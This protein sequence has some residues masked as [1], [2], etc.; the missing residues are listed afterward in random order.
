MS[1]IIQEI[2]KTAQQQDSATAKRNRRLSQLLW[3]LVVLYVAVLLLSPPDQLLP[4]EPIWAI[5]PDTL[6]EVLSESLNF[7]FVL[8]ILGKLLN[9]SAPVVHPA[10][11]AFFN[12]SEAWIFMFLPLMLL[13]RR[14]QNL[15]RGALWGAAMFLTNVFLMPY[16][17]Q[18]LRQPAVTDQPMPEKGWLARS[19]GLVGGIV[20]LGA[21]AW[22]CL[23]RPEFG[24]LA[25]RGLYFWQKLATDRVTIAFCVDLLL[26]W[27]FQIWLMGEII[28][29]D[30]KEHSLRWVPFWGL[31][32]WLLI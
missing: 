15:P 3:G 29:K 17:A 31:A 16:M 23:A 14:G 4:G 27:I 1:E 9:T 25:D 5:K 8:P 20:G 12:F 24:S 28:P 22:L 18:R 10:A 32:V 26:F 7:F 6:T 21:I 11:E 19:F 13:D 30:S 2:E